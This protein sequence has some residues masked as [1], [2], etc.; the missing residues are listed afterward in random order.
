M[1]GRSIQLISLLLSVVSSVICIDAPVK[2]LNLTAFQNYEGLCDSTTEECDSDELALLQRYTESIATSMRDSKL[3]MDP[4]LTSFEEESNRKIQ[5]KLERELGLCWDI[6]VRCRQ[7]GRHVKVI[8]NAGAKGVGTSL[9]AAWVGSWLIPWEWLYHVLNFAINLVAVQVFKSD[10][11]EQGPWL[12]SSVYK[13]LA[14]PAC[15]SVQYS[16]GLNRETF[17][18]GTANQDCKDL[19]SQLLVH[20]E[21]SHRTVQKCVRH[22]L[23]CGD[24]GADQRWTP[25]DRNGNCPWDDWAATA[26]DIRA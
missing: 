18:L 2:V 19:S 23:L 4:G 25:V 26:A 20:D 3:N 14:G 5:V 15:P 24:E 17:S 1:T 22:S 11:I 7:E 21:K 8:R 12:A 9:L 16:R 10:P 6:C 13:V